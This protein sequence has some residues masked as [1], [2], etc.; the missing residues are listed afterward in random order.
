[1]VG[2]A[3]KIDSKVKLIILKKDFDTL[4]SDISHVRFNDK[5]YYNGLFERSYSVFL[6][7]DTKAKITDMY[8][9]KV[10]GSDTFEDRVK[11]YED[12]PKSKYFVGSSLFPH[13]SCSDNSASPHNL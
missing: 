3:G 6:G 7:D 5:D 13:A 4:S 11:R 8:R 10:L 2:Y 12:R 1:M 9:T